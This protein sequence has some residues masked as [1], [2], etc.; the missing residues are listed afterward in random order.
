MIAAVSFALLVVVAVGYV[1][2]PLIVPAAPE[3][4]VCPAC[5]GRLTEGMNFCAGCGRSL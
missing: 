3:E 1:L 5:G 4:T 2:A